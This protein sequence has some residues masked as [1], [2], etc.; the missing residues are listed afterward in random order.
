MKKK[1]KSAPKNFKSKVKMGTPKKK[2]RRRPGAAAGKS[3]PRKSRRSGGLSATGKN[4]L[5]IVKPAA[6]GAAGGV[7]YGIASGFV[8]ANYRPWVGIGAAL[9]AVFAGVSNFGAGIAGASAFDY[10]RQT[11]GLADM[12]PV[13]YV[14]PTMLSDN[15]Q[16][17]EYETVDENGNV[18]ALNDAGTELMY[19]GTI[20]GLQGVALDPMYA[21]M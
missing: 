8:P 17:S 11:F 20:P 13:E 19:V 3:A 21:S 6:I 14:S 10:S 7:T 5:S 12:A 4:I 15:Y 16:L 18:Y 1:K 2:T 9:V